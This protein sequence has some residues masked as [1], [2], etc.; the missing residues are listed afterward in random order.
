MD[1]EERARHGEC[2]GRERGGDREPAPLAP[3]GDDERHEEDERGVLEAGG[4]PIATP[5]AGRRRVTISPSATATPSVI[6]TS[7]TA[8]REYATCVTRRR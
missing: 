4:V 6:G 5:A 1:D 3:A 7:V 8:I 2:D